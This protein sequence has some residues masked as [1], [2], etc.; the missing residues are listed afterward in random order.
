MSGQLTVTIAWIEDV[1]IPEHNAR[2]VGHRRLGEHRSLDHANARST[3][4][5][6]WSLGWWCA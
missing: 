2:S 1:L 6:S 5:A 3:A 4:S